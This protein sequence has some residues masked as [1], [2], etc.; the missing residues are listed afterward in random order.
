MNDFY[1]KINEFFQIKVQKLDDEHF[2][3]CKNLY[4]NSVVKEAMLFHLFKNMY[5]KMSGS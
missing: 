4:I 1:I 2:D 5:N 3:F